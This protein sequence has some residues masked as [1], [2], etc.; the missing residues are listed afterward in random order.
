[1]LEMFIEH[2]YNLYITYT[3]INQF[4]LTLHCTEEEGKKMFY[5]V[6]KNGLMI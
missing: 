6:D 2:F 3:N 5:S 1:M 4:L